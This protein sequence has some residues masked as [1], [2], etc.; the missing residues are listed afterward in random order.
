MNSADDS[1]VGAREVGAKQ[2]PAGE[3]GSGPGLGVLEEVEQQSGKASV[4]DF[5]CGELRGA[6]ATSSVL[7]NNGAA[8]W[9][10]EVR[11]WNGRQRHSVRHL[12]A[13]SAEEDADKWG[14]YVSEMVLTNQTQKFCFKIN[15]SRSPK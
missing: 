4:A 10:P 14:R 8:E 6:P 5:C 11:V 13:Q 12:N 2:E 15:S 7:S 3:I 1:G 9:T